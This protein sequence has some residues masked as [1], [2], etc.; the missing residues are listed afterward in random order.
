MNG[1]APTYRGNLAEPKLRI[2]DLSLWYGS[3]QVLR[4]ISLDIPA[5]QVTALIGPSGCG[6]S[7]LL[8]T[9][10]RMNDQVQG[11]RYEGQVLLDGQDVL[12]RRRDVIALRQRVGML[13]QRPNPFP[14]SVAENV[15]FGLRLCGAS[16]ARIARATR[17]CLGAVGL[18]DV[19]AGR[20]S[21]SSLE[22]SLE[23][24]QRLCLARALAT[25]PEV[26]LLDEPCSTLDPHA[27]QGIEAL[28][29]ALAARY[30]II[31]VTHNMQQAC[32]VADQTA[33]LLLG[34][35]VESG[36]TSTI[37]SAPRDPR[38]AGY[39]TGKYG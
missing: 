30:T 38:T 7:T 17:E 8:R 28:I 21:D 3:N 27:T 19:L 29:R 33:Y 26:L 34:E 31:I 18:W 36:A 24:Q 20:L 1:P 37:F 11:V 25:E 39:V 9:L 16:P 4:S 13:F 5:Q 6:K 32:R 15:A 22:L 14:L 12:D 23:Q 2:T 10:N 35:L